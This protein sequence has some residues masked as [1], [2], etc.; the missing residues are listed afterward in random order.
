MM[1]KQL[2]RQQHLAHILALCVEGLTLPELVYVARSS[3]VAVT[4]QTLARDLSTLQEYGFVSTK[5]DGPSR[6]YIPTPLCIKGRTRSLYLE[7]RI[8]KF[9]IIH[10]NPSDTVCSYARGTSP[11]GKRPLAL[12]PTR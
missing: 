11:N 2:T 4:I 1:L 3:G 7:T 9:A 6:L 8:P 12:Y 5:G 10:D